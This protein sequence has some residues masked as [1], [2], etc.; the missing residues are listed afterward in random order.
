MTPIRNKKTYIFYCTEVDNIFE[1]EKES[2]FYLISMML[3][4]TMGFNRTMLYL[5]EL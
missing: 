2:A 3:K 4:H 1:L 5:G